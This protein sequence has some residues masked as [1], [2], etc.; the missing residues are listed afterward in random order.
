MLIRLLTITA[1]FGFA[2]ELFAQQGDSL[3]SSVPTTSSDERSLDLPVIEGV[4]PWTDA[5]VLDDPDRFSIAIMTDRTGG[6]RP[7]VWMQGVRKVNLMRPDFV[8]S[9]GDLIEGYTEDTEQVER[10]WRE[11]LGFIDK[12]EMKFFFVAGNHDL[13]NPMMHRIWRKRFGREWYSFD[14]K[15]VH[16]LCLNSED[17]VTRIGEQQLQWIREDLEKSKDARWTLVFLHKPLWTYAERDLR[18]GNEDSTRWKTV[19]SMLK[20]RKHT[21]FAGHVH[22]YVEYDRNGSRYYSLATTGGGS[23]LRGKAYGEF[24]HFVWLTMERDGPRVANLMLNGVESSEVVTEKSIARF[25]EFLAEATFTAAPILIEESQIHQGL[26]DLQIV[27]RFDRPVTFDGRI[28]GLPLQGLTL[29]PPNVNV[30]VQ[31]GETKSLRTKVA[32]SEP[33]D[34]KRVSGATIGLKLSADDTR[35]LLA[36]MQKPVIIDRKFYWATH[37]CT[38]DGQLDEWERFPFKLGDAAEVFGSENQWQGKGDASAEFAMSVSKDQI[39]FAIQVEDDQVTEDDRLILVIDPRTT[40]D[41]A[42]EQRLQA[43]STTFVIAPQPDN[44]EPKIIRARTRNRQQVKET[45]VSGKLKETGNGYHVEFV[46]PK[47][48]LPSSYDFQSCQ[49]AVVI[50]DSDE[51]SDEDCWISWRS[52]RDFNRSNRSFG[53][54]FAPNQ[55]NGQ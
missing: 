54:L 31:P 20:D 1:V 14:Y 22:H 4:K 11:F 15:G 42:A 9:V 26:I 2:A 21:V 19:E 40:E 53:N 55:S 32:F 50:K 46:I 23:R 17:P 18:A 24:D 35:P 44:S 30:T 28:Q 39:A 45:K 6:H 34:L 36:E 43:D 38:P 7:G 51:K 13:S 52:A 37:D 12:L 49:L 41:R 5:P 25:R 47:S 33:V 27:N 16:F 29:Q 10:E 3:P 48:A 8:M